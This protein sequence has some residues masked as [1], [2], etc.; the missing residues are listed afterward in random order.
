MKNHKL[1]STLLS[2]VIIFVCATTTSAAGTR[3]GTVIRLGDT[4]DIVPYASGSIIN[5]TDWA[6]AGLSKESDGYGM[7]AYAAHV[8]SY[9]RSDVWGAYDVTEKKGEIK[10]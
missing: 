6:I 1:L 10:D 7:N 2:L 4:S 8:E 3:E 9:G 5:N